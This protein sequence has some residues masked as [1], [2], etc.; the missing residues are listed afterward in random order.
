MATYH[1]KNWSVTSSQDP[2]LPPE[3]QRVRLHGLRVEDD[4][5]VTTS[6]IVTVDGRN[7][8]T[9]SGSVYILEEINPDYLQ[10]LKNEGRTHDPDH[11]IKVIEKPKSNEPAK[12]KMAHCEAIAHPNLQ[13][14]WGCCN[15]RGFN[16]D[17][18]QSC[19]HCNH[20]R[21]DKD[22]GKRAN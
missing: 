16:G 20:N 3:A 14:G 6:Y 13:P 15:C 11:P 4:K 7:I 21:C 9:Y 5:E 1:L 19:R 17:Q 18:R 8:T 12:P 10:W 22:P 2:Y